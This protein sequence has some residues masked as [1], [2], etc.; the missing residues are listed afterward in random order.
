MVTQQQNEILA[1]HNKYRAEVGV[2]PLQ[3]SD[4]LAQGAQQWA[5]HLASTNQGGHSGTSG[6]SWAEGTT[7]YYTVTQLIDINWGAEKAKFI[8]GQVF[9]DFGELCPCSTTGKWTDVGHYTQIVWR[10][11]TEVGGGFASNGQNDFLVC[12]YSLPGNVHGENV[13]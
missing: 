1:A 10:N 11:T 5:N 4:R 8:P 2:S 7:G 12:R 3:W 6:E 13:Y 9:K